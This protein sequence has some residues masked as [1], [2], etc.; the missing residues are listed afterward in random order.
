MQEG[1][2]KVLS[3]GSRA[4]VMHGTAKK[5]SGGLTKKDLMYNKQG[6]IVSRAKAKLARAQKHLRK[7]GWTAK[8][9]QFGAI[10]MKFYKGSESK[11]RKG[12]KDFV[13]H[14]G[15]KDFNREDHRQK[16]AK[17]SRKVRKPYMK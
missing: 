4:Q 5:T 1:G 15:D 3:V 10:R 9:G 14:K 7:A 17:G 6:E 16:H 12:R 2:K 8:K 11:T 13:T